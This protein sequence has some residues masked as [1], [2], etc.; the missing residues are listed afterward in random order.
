M[1]QRAEWLRHLGQALR[2]C[3]GIGP[4]PPEIPYGQRTPLNAAWFGRARPRSQ[5]HVASRKFSSRELEVAAL[6]A[7]DLGNK[8]I[9]QRLSIDEATVKSH[10]HR[11]SKK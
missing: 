10:L 5:S 7:Q 6:V 8:E 3:W 1:C 11:L 4:A 9:G 2:G